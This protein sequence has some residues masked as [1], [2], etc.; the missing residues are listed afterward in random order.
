MRTVVLSN[1]PTAMV[2]PR[3]VGP[4]LQRRAG[5]PPAS[6]AALDDCVW[7]DAPAE[8]EAPGREAHPP[9]HDDVYEYEAFCDE[10]LWPLLHNAAS[11]VPLSH[12][13]FQAYESVNARFALR[14]LQESD[15]DDDVFW[16]HDFALMLAP[17]FLH[18]GRPHARVGFF[19]QEPFP[20][21]QVFAR[22]P[23]GNALLRG[24]L[25]ADLL[26]FPTESSRDAFLAAV[27]RLPLVRVHR[28]SVALHAG[29]TV[30]AEVFAPGIQRARF[31]GPADVHTTAE[32][33]ALQAAWPEARLLLAVNP[34]DS[35]KDIPRRLLAFE[36]LLEREPDFV[37]KVCLVQIAVPSREGA[38]A[39][40]PHHEH[41]AELVARI[42]GRYGAAGSIP[43]VRYLT[44][45]LTPEA[46]VALY[47]ACDVMVVTPLREASNSVA[48]EFVAARRDLGGALVLSELGA[49]AEQL[50]DAVLLNPYDLDAFADALGTALRMPARE[51]RDRMARLRASVEAESPDAWARSFLERLRATSQRHEGR[52]P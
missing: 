33:A 28:A 46:R 44:R 3:P 14:A 43:P 26:G 15:D 34:L 9:L 48:K 40:T 35:A 30:R 32:F 23:S 39:D 31:E 49:A 20:A 11:S 18:V 50:C 22:L 21:P 19:L 13:G 24:A 42:N 7:I 25:S 45:R 51:R 29:R 1:R 6:I 10:V 8:P 4:A 16:V 52:H 38:H 41:V 2:T 5:A 17:S 27:S 37:G 47:R 12:D 36:R